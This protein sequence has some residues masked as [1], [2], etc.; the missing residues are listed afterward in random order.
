MLPAR[1]RRP[2]SGG[3]PKGLHGRW[4]STGIKFAKRPQSIGRV[5]SSRATRR[6]TWMRGT[7]GKGTARSAKAGRPA[8]RAPF[9]NRKSPPFY[10]CFF[11]S[12]CF[13][14]RSSTRPLSL[15]GQAKCRPGRY[16]RKTPNP[17]VMSHRASADTPRRA[18]RRHPTGVDEARIAKENKNKPL[19]REKTKSSSVKPRAV[20]AII[21][22]RSATR[23][24]GP[25]SI[26]IG[27]ALSPRRRWGYLPRASHQQARDESR[28]FSTG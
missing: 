5:S 26:F 16:I 24:A 7:P 1:L 12:S 25:V 23:S 17:P 4:C 11:S 9:P 21:A 18:C 8:D 14:Q 2:Q 13:F 19:Y 28:Q 15:P 6:G 3:S 20:L 22:A 27:P 10:A